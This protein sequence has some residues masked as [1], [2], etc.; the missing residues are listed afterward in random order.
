MVTDSV[1]CGIDSDVSVG[2]CSD[3]NHEDSCEIATISGSGDD[4]TGPE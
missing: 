3:E 1:K 4:T 2:G